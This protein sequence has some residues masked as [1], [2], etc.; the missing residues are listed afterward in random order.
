MQVNLNPVLRLSGVCLALALCCSAYAQNLIV[1]GN[2]S[3]GNTGFTSQYTYKTPPATGQGQ[4]Y[5]GANPNSWYSGFPAF[6]DHT[7][8]TAAG[9]MLMADAGTVTPSLAVWSQSVTV[10]ANST[11][12]FGMWLANIGTQ[13]TAQIQISINGV[14]QGGIAGAS[15]NG[16]WQFFSR[17]WTSGASTLALI[18]L[19]DTR[20]NANGNDFALDD[21][22]LVAAPEPGTLALISVPAVTLL[23]RRRRR[24]APA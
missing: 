8:G 13:N 19:R 9:S 22:H 23:L 18:E 17:E 24:M 15:G 14:V 4:Y 2:F 11:Y 5:V 12:Q 6:F 20:I 3:A 21:L 7:T 16:N 10:K 1:N